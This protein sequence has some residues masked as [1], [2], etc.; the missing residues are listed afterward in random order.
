MQGNILVKTPLTL[1]GNAPV[2]GGDG[3]QVYSE[4]ILGAAAKP[5]LEKRN[6]TL[7]PHLKVIIQDYDGPLGVKAP[8]EQPVELP[9]A[10]ANAKS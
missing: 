9:K 1:D 6:T 10:K 3:R 7:P 8:N 5:V 2:I 4:S